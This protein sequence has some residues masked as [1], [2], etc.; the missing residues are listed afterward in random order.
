VGQKKNKA[1][2]NWPTRPLAGVCMHLTSLPSPL[3]IGDIGDASLAFIDQ[4]ADM[5]L[6]VWQVLPIGPTAFGDSPY[7]TL[8]AFAGN[9][10][11]VGLEPLVRQGLLGDE[12]LAP[13]KKL[14]D[15]VVE[16]ET[17]VPL[18]RAL[19]ERAAERFLST[20]APN[21]LQAFESFCEASG[22]TWL[23]DYALFRSLK[24]HHD[25]RAW[26]GWTPGYARRKKSAIRRAKAEFQQAIEII[27]V[28]QFFFDR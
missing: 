28:I 1:A 12:E 18:K 13:L 15:S 16:F 8:S 10:M 22:A 23:D 24:T 19:L 7:Q 26:T 3:G 25:E 11:L 6:R 27:K 17:L 21:S 14:P 9:E 2:K 20:S 4:L 5:K